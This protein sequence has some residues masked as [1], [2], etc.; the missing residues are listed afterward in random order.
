MNAKKTRLCGVLLV[1]LASSAGSALAFDR[2]LS[3]SATCNAKH[4]TSSVEF[5]TWVA[6]NNS[7]VEQ[8]IMCGITHNLAS[9]DTNDDILIYFNDRNPDSG[10]NIKCIG[11]SYNTD[12]STGF[13]I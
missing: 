11:W 4:G 1:A 5:A 7:S 8:I 2:T 10:K 9:L 12:H 3:P 6:N 13:T